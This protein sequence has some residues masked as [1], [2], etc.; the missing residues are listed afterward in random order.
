MD[1][2][3]LCQRARELAKICQDKIAQGKNIVLTGHDMPDSDSILSCVLLQRLLFRL[4]VDSS[5]KFA[6]APD[7]V[8]LRDM[9]KLGVMDDVGLDGFDE[10][11]ALVLADHHVTE[12]GGAFACV[13]H[14]TTPPEPCLEWSF[15]TKASSCGKI[16]YDM[17]SSCSL[18]KDDDE[19]LAIYSVFL[20]TQ[21][22]QSP[23]FDLRDLAWLEDGIFRLG[24]DR[25]EITKMGYC[26]MLPD[27]SPETLAMYGYKQYSFNGRL[28]ASSCIQ[29]DTDID[30]WRERIDEIITCIEEIMKE[31]KIFLWAFVLNKPM[32]NRSDIYFIDLSGEVR[33]TELDRLASR[34][35]DVVP[36]IKELA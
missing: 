23:K 27:E 33:L 20:D 6:T 36:V 21:S 15:V 24:I 1:S 26:L 4:G 9:K 16:I 18:A 19:R 10:D 22:C 12:Y 3:I 31:K 28:G 34:S 17:L 11:D 7:S 2:E 8:T 30:L 5:I 25:E 32:D 29:I 35:R 14:H 13:D